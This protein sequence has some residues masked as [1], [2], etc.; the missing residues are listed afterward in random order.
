MYIVAWGAYFLSILGRTLNASSEFRSRTEWFTGQWILTPIVLCAFVIWPWELGLWILCFVAVG[1][2][3]WKY[4][5]AEWGFILLPLA[6]IFE[7]FGLEHRVSFMNLALGLAGLWLT[8]ATLDVQNAH[9]LR[10]FWGSVWSPMEGKESSKSRPWGW[11]ETAWMLSLGL[12]EISLATWTGG[13]VATSADIVESA[14]PADSVIM[15]L[16]ITLWFFLGLDGAYR[17]V[18]ALTSLYGYRL[19]SN[20][21]RPWRAIDVADHWRRWHVPVMRWLNFF[22]Y[23]PAR[24]KLRRWPHAHVVLT[25]VIFVIAGQ[26][27]RT[28]WGSLIWG[29]LN[30]VLVLIT[31]TMFAQLRR[32]FAR[33]GRIG[34][35]IGL[36]ICGGLTA[37]L[38]LLMKPLVAVD[39]ELYRSIV[40]RIA[41]ARVEG[42]GASSL[43][44]DFA[45]VIFVTMTVFSVGEK[46]EKYIEGRSPNGRI[47]LI[48]FGFALTL[49]FILGLG[50]TLIRSAGI[51]YI[52]GD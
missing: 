39:L 6:L 18:R 40:L 33:L 42:W 31:P 23:T 35:R 49:P 20:F 11:L 1:L 48:D 36:L 14:S 2:L 15:I 17:V 32:Q 43:W 3:G 4:L 51:P 7:N 8:K 26:L 28:G 25:F 46:V 41:D 16:S 38:E 5:P 24:V 50:L 29:V 52:G 12:F 37:F 10:L 13:I 44:D 27:I 45:F 9:P 21:D 47:Q 19:S 22:I 30:S 34:I